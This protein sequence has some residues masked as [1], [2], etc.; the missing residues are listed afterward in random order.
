MNGIK[1]KYLPIGSVVS[2]NGYNRKIM[3]TGFFKKN[4]DGNYC[5]YSG[6]V[7]PEGNVIGVAEILFNHEQITSVFYSGMINEEELAYKEILKKFVA[8]IIPTQSNTASTV[9]Q[10][11]VENTTNVSTED[12]IAILD[13]NNIDLSAPVAQTP[14]SSQTSPDQ[15]VASNQEQGENPEGKEPKYIFDSEGTL[16]AIE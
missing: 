4:S 10:Q 14:E 1:E 6:C 9:L 16:V 8:N 5:D 13:I 2:I 15:V 11:N 12:G 3:I 7:Y